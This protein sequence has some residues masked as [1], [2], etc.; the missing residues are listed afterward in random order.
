MKI[1]KEAI[2]QY[3]LIYIL[4]FASGA[5]WYT[6]SQNAVYIVLGIAI[7]TPLFMGKMVIN[8]R[9]I[10]FLIIF[11]T[12]IIVCRLINNGGIGLNY[13]V[14]FGTKALI[15]YAAY[16]I[17]KEK[18][19]RR[20]LNII[21]ALAVF[22]LIGFAISQVQPNIL[23]GM[24][25]QYSTGNVR[26]GYDNVYY[27][28]FLYTYQ[29]AERNCGIYTE[30]ALYQMI[31]TSGLFV[32]LYAPHITGFSEKKTL[33]RIIIL[34]ITMISTL[35]ATA[36]ISY[37]ILSAPI[38]LK[39]SR[40][41]GR[42]KRYISYILG[43]AIAILI[44]DFSMNGEKSILSVY[45][46]GKM[47]D[48][49]TSKGN[50]LQSG[51]ARIAVAEMALYSII[52]H[53]LGI[54]ASGY[55]N[56]SLAWNYTNAAGNGLFYYLMVLG[57]IGWSIAI[58]YIMIPAY[59]NRKNRGTFYIFVLIYIIATV[60]QSYIFSPV[61]LFVSLLDLNSRSDNRDSHMRLQENE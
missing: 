12:S 9:F 55:V 2:V 8:K 39:K 4:L 29:N 59:R 7:I 24:M 45:L 13:V 46:I 32:L 42:I 60:S 3:F 25:S 57:I 33:S 10:F 1:S 50:N 56:M 49:G 35:S 15:A 61:F 34:T 52:R 58:L 41:F 30:P 26:L 5:A 48:M 36:Y 38:F 43:I 40:E 54:G 17:N 31:L 14:D 23:T 11:T 28:K 53:P 20:F 18:A 37:L 19:P 47:S 16:C 21:T 44:L 27:G 6:V 22:S 51:D